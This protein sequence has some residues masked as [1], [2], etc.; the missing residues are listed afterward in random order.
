[1]C[2]DASSRWTLRGIVS[3]GTDPCAGVDLTSVKPTVFSNVFYFVNWTQS[4]M[5][6]Y[7]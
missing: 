7:T 2:K 6:M 4:I 5:Q 1:M 3:F